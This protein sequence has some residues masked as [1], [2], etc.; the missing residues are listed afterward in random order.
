MFPAAVR[1]LPIKDLKALSVFSVDGTIDMQ[2]LTDLKKYV[3]PT[4]AAV[5]SVRV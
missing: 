4:T 2:D 5:Q 1:L 3:R